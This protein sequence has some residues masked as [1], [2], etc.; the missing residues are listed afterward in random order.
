M[1]GEEM[2]LDQVMRPLYDVTRDAGFEIQHTEDYDQTDWIK[3][4]EETQRSGVG[5]PGGDPWLLGG[6]GMRSREK[7]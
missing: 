3:R 5:L 1:V 2:D 7:P 4:Y 6:T